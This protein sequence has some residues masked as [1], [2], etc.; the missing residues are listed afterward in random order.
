MDGGTSATST[1]LADADRLV[2]N[3]NGTMK[4]VALT[5]LQTYFS[6]GC[7]VRLTA[8]VSCATSGTAVI[9]GEEISSVD[10]GTW[11]EAYDVGGLHDGSSNTERF[12]FG[13]TGKYLVTV[14]QQWA[15]DAAGYRQVEIMLKPNG[16][17]AYSV[18]TD[19]IS[20]APGDVPAISACST[21]VNVTNVADYIYVQATQTS[22]A[23]LS[24]MGNS[25][26]TATQ[27]TTLTITRLGA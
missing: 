25:S 21:V 13:A 4:Q 22:G 24:I 2:M 8:D 17:T 20:S 14:T 10:G 3:D 12:V 7:S 6:R 9:L 19:R 16:V 23:A 11:T 18:L 26:G 1:T 27:E 15:A 5:D